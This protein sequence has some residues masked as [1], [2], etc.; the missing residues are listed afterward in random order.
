M[1]QL[2]DLGRR[3]DAAQRLQTLLAVAMSDDSG[4]A[5]EKALRGA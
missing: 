3:P 1:S 2:P 4:Q 5:L